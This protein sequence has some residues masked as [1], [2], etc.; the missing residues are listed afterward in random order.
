ML[1]FGREFCTHDTRQRAAVP[2][3]PHP[4]PSNLST[5]HPLPQTV[6]PLRTEDAKRRHAG[7]GGG[8]SSSSST[9]ASRPRTA[10]VC[11][12]APPNSSAFPWPPRPTG[13]ESF[14]QLKTEARSCKPCSRVT[15]LSQGPKEYMD[16][17]AR[18]NQTQEPEPGVWARCAFQKRMLEVFTGKVYA[19]SLPE[20]LGPSGPCLAPS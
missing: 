4:H 18:L 6:P 10:P 5:L 14:F 19:R 16:L 15:E 2:Y 12:G 17:R 9:R 20:A 1:F 3:T 7:G 11:F 13:A 8:G